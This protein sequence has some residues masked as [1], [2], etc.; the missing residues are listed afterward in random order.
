MLV[1]EEVSFDHNGSGGL[2]EDERLLGQPK[3]RSVEVVYRSGECSKK[4]YWH[5]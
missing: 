3:P 1:N 5:G 4:F 2:A